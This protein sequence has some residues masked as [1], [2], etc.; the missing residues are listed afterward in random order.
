MLTA[1]SFIV[2]QG[3]VIGNKKRAVDNRPKKAPLCKGGL[4]KIFDF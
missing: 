2:S 4:A 3:G 1:F